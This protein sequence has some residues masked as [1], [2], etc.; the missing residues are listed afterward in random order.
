MISLIRI[1]ETY[2]VKIQMLLI[3]NMS[4]ED[5]EQLGRDI[6]NNPHV[7]RLG[8]K[9]DALSNQKI[10][11]LFRGLQKSTTITRIGLQ[12]NQLSIAG[13]R[14]LV[15]FLQNASN[16]KDFSLG[17]SNNNIQSEGF[18]MLLQA[19]RDSQIQEFSLGCN[20]CGIDS[21]EINCEHIPRHLSGLFLSE[22]SINTDG[23]H[24]LAKLH[25]LTTLRLEGNIIN[26]DGCRELAE[27][28]QG[29]DSNLQDVD[30][31]NN[32]ID[33]EGVEILANA[34]QS[35]TSLTR[36]DLRGNDE[37]SNQ[38]L[39]MLLKL[40][41]N[42][43]SIKATLQSNHTLGDLKV[44]D[45]NYQFRNY[46]QP[47]DANEKLQQRIDSASYMAVKIYSKSKEDDRIAA[48]RKKVMQTQLHSV[49]R[50]EL[51][52]I[53]GVS[54][55]LYSEIDPIHLPE[56]LALV[57]KHHGQEELYM[58]LKSSIAGVISTVDKEQRLI[59]RIAE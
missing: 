32:K 5:W 36:L 59:R 11:Y 30:L 29:G 58:A 9:N 56:V 57:D 47:F 19:L 52:E 44:I 33:D 7:V 26:S 2:G 39:V 18:N 50:A 16:L 31:Q 20:S 15:P 34:L 42:I 40:M 14:S 1:G 4:N 25:Y 8:F 54:H 17:L 37:I 51:A 55:S 28:L 53:Q 23:C 3:Q 22:N 46:R 21:I 27:L 38:G 13:I 24:E 48:G 45:I 41:N 12:N 35:N 49:K 6:A 43:S 10:S